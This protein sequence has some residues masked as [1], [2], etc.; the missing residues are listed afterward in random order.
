MVK[1]HSGILG[2]KAACAYPKHFV[3]CHALLRHYEPSHPPNS[4]FYLSMHGFIN[5]HEGCLDYLATR[6]TFCMPGCFT[7]TGKS[8]TFP[9][10]RNSKNSQEMNMN[11]LVGIFL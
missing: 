2:S 5:N 8:L 7:I 4:L 11:G 3:A 10:P 9:V 6:Q 1:S